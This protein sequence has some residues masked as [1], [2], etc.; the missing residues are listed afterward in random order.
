MKRESPV[1]IPFRTALSTC[2]SSWASIS[3]FVNPVP[4]AEAFNDTGP[5]VIGSLRSKPI[6]NS[7][8]MT[9]AFQRYAFEP[10][11]C[12]EVNAAFPF[13]FPMLVVITVDAVK[14]LAVPLKF[15][16]NF[17]EEG[18]T[19]FW[20]TKVSAAIARMSFRPEEKRRRSKS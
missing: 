6:L 2:T 9:S 15:P 7:S 14:F 20:G 17:I 13:K 16:L 12:V 10:G 5:N 1:G 8:T 11:F 3:S 4:A 18:N 19:M